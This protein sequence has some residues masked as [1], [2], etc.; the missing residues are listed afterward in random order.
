[1]ESIDLLIGR[2]PKLVNCR[3][4]ILHA[5]EL[6]T[7]GFRRGGTLFTCG[8]GT[9]SPSSEIPWLLFTVR[10]ST[11]D[12]LLVKLDGAPA[13][14]AAY[15]YSSVFFADPALSEGQ[16]YPLQAGSQ[17]QEGKASK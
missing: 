8:S 10:G 16:S 3:G 12:E 15:S 11:G 14:T 9:P 13:M 17:T 4:D 6:L 7:E 5:A 2:Y 1:M